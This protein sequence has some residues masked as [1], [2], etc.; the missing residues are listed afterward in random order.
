MGKSEAS[1][2]LDLPEAI[3]IKLPDEALKLAVP[4]KLWSDFCLH[5]LGIEYIN[6]GFGGVPGYDF[7]ELRALGYN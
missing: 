1:L 6:V 4:E 2:T 7:F 5:Q 3:K